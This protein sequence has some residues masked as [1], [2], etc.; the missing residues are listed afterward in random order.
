[1]HPR[2]VFSPTPLQHPRP[3]H[4]ADDIRQGRAVDPC[5]LDQDSL[6]KARFRRHSLEHRRLASCHARCRWRWPFNLRRGPCF[7]C[8]LMRQMDQVYYVVHMRP[9]LYLS[10]GGAYAHVALRDNLRMSG[11]H[12]MDAKCISPCAR[13]VFPI[14]NFPNRSDVPLAPVLRVETWET[15]KAGKTGKLVKSMTW[16][17]RYW[18]N[19]K[20]TKTNRWEGWSTGGKRG[21]SCV[22]CERAPLVGEISGVQPGED[23]ND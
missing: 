13:Q 23:V 6:A 3:T 2:I 16:Q 18:E 11:F 14:P 8:A 22:G 20:T 9:A 17:N 21:S 12:R 5:A 15:G 19:G 7:V 4:P 1:M 10:F